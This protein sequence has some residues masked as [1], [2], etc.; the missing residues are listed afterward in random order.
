M[1]D[2]L[3]RVVVLK[4]TFTTRENLSINT[5]REEG[6]RDSVVI[7]EGGPH[8]NPVI[9]GSSVK[10]VVRSTL[11]ALLSQAGY[12][13]CVPDTC[14]SP[15]VSGTRLSARACAEAPRNKQRPCLVCELFGNTVQAGRA[16]FQDAR[17]P[18]DRRVQTIERTHVA[19]TRDTHTAARGALVTMETIPAAETFH[20]EV[21]IVNPQPW[22]VGA[23]LFVL[24]RL[25][26][27][28]I[29]AKRSSGYGSLEVKVNEIWEEVYHAQ[30][31]P[32]YQDKQS[33]RG[34]WN[35]MIGRQGVDLGEGQLWQAP[36]V[37]SA[38]GD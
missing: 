13:I 6:L 27:F 33:L 25:P 21:V 38:G 29:G 37:A 18:R 15:G 35:E 2:Q 9:S 4:V 34:I 24:E 36:V 14:R 12:E 17:A 23:I 30:P 3:E 20:G 16:N 8:T 32:V 7:R 22:M 28:G 31:D 26:A 19:L 5:G 11:E 10:G 1:F